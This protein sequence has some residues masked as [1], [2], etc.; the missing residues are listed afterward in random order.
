[1]K[2]YRFTYES[3]TS[4]SVPVTEHSFMLRS[5]PMTDG[6]GGTQRLLSH[7]LRITPG[8]DSLSEDRDAWGAR[9]DYGIVRA[10]HREFGYCSSGTVEVKGGP[11]PDPSP[12][13]MFLLPTGLTAFVPSMRSFIPEK[14]MPGT[15]VPGRTALALATEMTESVFRGI[16]YVPGSTG[17]DTTAGTAFMQGKGVCQD[18]SHILIAL[19]RECGIPARYVCGFVIGEG[20]THA[21]TEIW[22]EGSWYPLDATSGLPC[23]D[24][25]IAV[26]YGRDARDC[27]VSRGVFTGAA[28]QQTSTRV[29]VE[30]LDEAAAAGFMG[31]AG[32]IEEA[33]SLEDEM[34]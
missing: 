23:D 21:W 32:I 24:R 6:E 31:E 20:E 11:H 29:L 33:S 5:V 15:M 26:A 25:Y 16:A 4:F 18:F 9:T 7:S 28:L 34:R 19:C 12:S 22:S 3:K 27:S 14:A 1:M 8:P 17:I 13:P 2:C 10:P 30:E